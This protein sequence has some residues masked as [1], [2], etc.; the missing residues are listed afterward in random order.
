MSENKYLETK[1]NFIQSIYDTGV[2][3]R[4]V[5]DQSEN[6]WCVE[7]VGLPKN[8]YK[9]HGLRFYGQTLSQAIDKALNQEVSTSIHARRGPDPDCPNCD[10]T[11]GALPSGVCGVCWTHQEV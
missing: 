7:T 1:L 11:G 3:V 2:T 4:S 6:K 10:G 8:R 5:H 9:D